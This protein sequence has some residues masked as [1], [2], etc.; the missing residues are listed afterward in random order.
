MEVD[1]RFFFVYSTSYYAL[2]LILYFAVK[3]FCF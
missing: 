2:A 1:P 3:L